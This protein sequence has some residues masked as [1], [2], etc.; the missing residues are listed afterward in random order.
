M[1]AIFEPSW[2]I[3]PSLL[4]IALGVWALTRA[5]TNEVRFWRADAMD[6][7]KPRALA[8]G[9]RSMLLGVS[10]VAFGLAWIFQVVWLWWLALV[11][12]AEESWETS[13][14]IFGLKQDERFKSE[15][16]QSRGSRAR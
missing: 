6:M 3:W 4:S 13:M 2:R 10:L 8:A 1:D 15:Y 5:A 16:A 7:A 9:I 11:F 14:M 12:G